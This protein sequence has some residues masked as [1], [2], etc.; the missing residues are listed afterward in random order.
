[1]IAPPTFRGA[2]ALL[3]LTLMCG[4]LAPLIGDDGPGGPQAI[5]IDHTS[6]RLARIPAEWI[7]AAKKSLHIAYGHT[8]HGSQLVDGMTGLVRWKGPLYA[9]NGGGEGGALDLR[10]YNGDFGGLGIAGDLGGDTAGNMNRKAWEKATRLYLIQ[11]PDVNVVVWSW[12][13]QVG[14][15][16]DDIRLYLDL[17]GKLEKDY[18]RVRFV[19]MTGRVDGTPL[20]GPPWEIATVLRN[21]QIRD[22]CRKHGKILYDFADIES[23]DPDGRYFGDKRL[24][25]HCDYD[26]DG[27]GRRDRNWA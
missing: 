8:S 17:M 5:V 10:A 24:N 25:D 21:R 22:Y 27:D 23:Y 16:E 1:M 20:D 4:L 2:R 19:Y 15:T 14:G 26:S 18:P 6:T 11:N 13:W 12:C 3:L 9:W 7:A